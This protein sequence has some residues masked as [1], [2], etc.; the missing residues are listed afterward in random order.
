MLTKAKRQGR[1]GKNSA[2]QG[3]DQV[4][5]SLGGYQTGFPRRMRMTHRYFDSV[6]MTGT[7]GANV[8]QQWKANGMFDPNQTGTGAQPVFFDNMTALYDHWVV[9]KSHIKTEFTCDVPT[10][11]CTYID[12]DTSLA[13]DVTT[14]L[15]QPSAKGGL[16]PQ[17]LAVPYVVELDWVASQS[18]GP[19]PETNANLI[20]TSGADPTEVE[21]FTTLIR[22]GIPA[23]STVVVTAVTID[24]YCEWFEMRNQP[25]S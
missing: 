21:F 15:L 25:Y 9:I 5:R 1:R 12:D 22:S 8:S 19:N 11:V 20:G 7:S 17:T 16:I 24:Y 23:T 13:T 4:F 10:L 3:K 2:S 6:V 18:F 14:A